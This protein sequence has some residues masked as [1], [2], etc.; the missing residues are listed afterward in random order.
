MGG[1]QEIGYWPEDFEGYGCDDNYILLKLY[2]KGYEFGDVPCA[3]LQ[4]FSHDAKD[5]D[6]VSRQKFIETYRGLVE[7]AKTQPHEV[8]LNFDDFNP[9]NN[10]LFFFRKLKENYPNL[11]VTLFT[12]PE[13]I[14]SGKKESFLDHP[15][16]CDELREMDW[17]EFCPHGWHHP[18]MK[19]GMPPEFGSLSYMDTQA[20]IKDIDTFFKTINLPYKK[21]FKAPQYRLSEAAKDCFR[22]NGWTIMIDGEGA[23]YPTDIKTV[24]YN[25]NINGDFPILRN[26]VISYGHIQDIGNGLVECWDKLLQMPTDSNFK[27]ISQLWTY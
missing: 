25:W 10:N 4:H 13:S 15:D 11:K 26:K 5:D 1:M 20:Y 23:W 12:T 19:S 14:Q 2:M 18:D 16:L 6:P 17:L 22:D 7:K 3:V 27:F 9:V 24:Y 8:Y 21:I